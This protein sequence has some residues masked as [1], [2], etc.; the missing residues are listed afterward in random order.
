[1]SD[2]LTTRA[3]DDL[4]TFFDEARAA[5]ETSDV[6]QFSDWR[7]RFNSNSKALSREIAEY[8]RHFRTDDDDVHLDVF[9]YEGAVPEFGLPFEPNY[10]EPGKTKIKEHVASHDEGQL[11]LK[12]Q[13]GVHL[14][15]LGGHRV[16]AGPLLD[17]PNQVV[18]FINNMYLEYLLGH[19]GQL[20]HAAG[21]AHGTIGLGLAGQSGKGKSTLALR[22][23]ELG[24]D[25][26]SNDR[27]VVRAGSGL[28]M[29]GIPKYP[30]IN[31]GTIVNQEALL[32]LATEEDLARYRAMS[33]DE[34]WDLEEKYDAFVEPCFPGCRFRLE[35]EMAMFVVV[36]WDR[37]STE[38][39]RLTRVE[40]GELGRLVDTIMKSPGILLPNA[41]QRI[42]VARAEDYLA[43]L[44]E[45]RLYTL[46]GGVDFDGAARELRDRLI[47]GDDWN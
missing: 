42:P 18:N 44:G 8:Y 31:P 10:P 28:R 26:V 17:N 27:L 38:P 16:C 34:L 30:R 15:Y 2:S 39:F 12:V 43:L 29:A 19:G 4:S 33:R 37:N 23:L 41:R 45:T 25:L 6:F 32:G 46:T 21:V 22:L 20:F 7:V 5:C 13:T 11:V 47:D 24:L 3:G 36:A 35:A 9:G 14:A 1:M 40:P